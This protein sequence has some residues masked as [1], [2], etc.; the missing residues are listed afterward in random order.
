MYAIYIDLIFPCWIITVTSKCI[1][2]RINE[3]KT[4]VLGFSSGPVVNWWGLFSLLSYRPRWPCLLY[5]SD[6]ADE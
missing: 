6:A 1:R 4:E 2:M 3:L 5:T